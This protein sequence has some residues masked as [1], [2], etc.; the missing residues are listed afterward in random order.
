MI[1][2]RFWSKHKQTVFYDVN[3]K[4][5]QLTIERWGWSNDSVEKAHELAQLRVQ[6]AV[7]TWEATRNS[8]SVTFWD[9]WKREPKV[10]YNGAEGVPIREEILQDR[11]DVGVLTRNSYGAHCLNTQHMFIADIDKSGITFRSPHLLSTLLVAMILVC[12]T[13]LLFSHFGLWRS[14]AGGVLCGGVVAVGLRFLLWQ[15]FVL[16]S[17]GLAEVVKG[18]LEEHPGL[19]FRLYET[20][21][22]FRVLETSK[23]FVA[24]ASDT[25]DLFAS[26][27][28]DKLYA[29]MCK[30]QLCFR[31]RVSGKPWR[32]DMD[33]MPSHVWPV[34]EEDKLRA[35]NTWISQYEERSHGFAAA[36]L[37]LVVGEEKVDAKIADTLKWH[38]EL[39]LNDNK[40]L[41]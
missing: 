30:R 23:P 12:F 24:E 6:E 13:V 4:K 21:N 10:P 5:R 19:S 26:M 29:K 14:L 35:R 22:G 33:K 16:G 39:T 8:Q 36:R 7:S 31:A 37:L 25:Q 28:T 3:G 2:G 27:Q 1:V 34:V 17:G 40:P 32:M 41:A 15:V 38:D 11:G 9:K 20:P 18:R